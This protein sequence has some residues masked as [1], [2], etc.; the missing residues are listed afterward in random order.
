MVEIRR[1][2]VLLMMMR[3]RR[4]AAERALLNLDGL[5]MIGGDGQVRKQHREM[6]GGVFQAEISLLAVRFKIHNHPK[7]NSDFI[8][9]RLIV[10]AYFSQERVLVAFL[11]CWLLSVV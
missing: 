10:H 6:R 9:H 5:T 7:G 11:N 1:E 8:F 4:N 2:E 3:R